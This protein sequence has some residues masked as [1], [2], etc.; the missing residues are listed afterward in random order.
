MS[1]DEALGFGSLRY[2]SGLRWGVTL[3]LD[4]HNM[5]GQV[6]LSRQLTVTQSI[7]KPT[8][9]QSSLVEGVVCYTHLVRSHGLEMRC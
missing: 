6:R 5:I 4:V 3:R 1:S 9:T 7:A 8:V 2:R